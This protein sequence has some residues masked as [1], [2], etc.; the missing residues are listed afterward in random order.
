MQIRLQTPRKVERAEN[1]AGQ[2]VCLSVAHPRQPR[3]HKRLPRPKQLDA[4][5]HQ[6]ATER[7]ARGEQALADVRIARVAGGTRKQR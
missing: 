2:L 5:L 7:V 4:I 6:N 3:A 1:S